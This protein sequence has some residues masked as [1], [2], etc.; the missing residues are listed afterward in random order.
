MFKII[1]TASLLAITELCSGTAASTIRIKL[2][3]KINSVFHAKLA[4]GNAN[5]VMAVLPQ[6]ISILGGDLTYAGI[7]MTVALFDVDN[8]GNFNEINKDYILIGPA[9]AVELYTHKS[10]QAC[11]LQRETFIQRGD[12]AFKVINISPAGK[13]IDLQVHHKAIPH[14]AKLLRYF[15]K[16]PDK[17]VELISGKTVNLQDFSGRSQYIYI[18][19]WGT[20]CPGCITEIDELQNIY[21]RYKN[22]LLIIGLNFK[23]ADRREVEEFVRQKKIPWLNGYSTSEINSELMQAAFPYGVL[24]DPQGALV[25]MDITQRELRVFLE[26]KFGK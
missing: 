1:I 25:H 23:D 4:E 15:N 7:E 11:E 14:S 26:E 3:R 6:T 10:I 21:T 8:D 18:D 19:I 22:N 2:S 16:L 12:V 13:F 24:F 20:W 17:A 9:G 5:A